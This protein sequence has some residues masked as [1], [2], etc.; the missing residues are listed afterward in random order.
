MGSCVTNMTNTKEHV[1]AM[2]EVLDGELDTVNK[3]I[4]KLM[5]QAEQIIACKAKLMSAQ[6]MKELE[7]KPNAQN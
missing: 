2:L 4:N 5:L 6:L 7:D 3:K 1:D